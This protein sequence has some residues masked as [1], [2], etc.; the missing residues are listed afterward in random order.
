MLPPTPLSFEGHCVSPLH[1]PRCLM[2]TTRPSLLEIADDLDRLLRNQRA[3]TVPVYMEVIRENRNHVLRKAIQRGSRGGNHLDRATPR[4]QRR[5]RFHRRSKGRSTIALLMIEFQN[6]FATA[7]GK[8]FAS[9]RESIEHTNI[10]EN[11]AAAWATGRGGQREWAV[12]NKIVMPSLTQPCLL[13][14]R[15]LSDGRRSVRRRGPTVVW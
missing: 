13:R 15:V 2:H 9:V 5:R 4:S 1:L 7:G 10:L 12:Q 14:L 6:E 11:A 8:L 3:H